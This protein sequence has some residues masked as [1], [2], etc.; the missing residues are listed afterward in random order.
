MGQASLQNARRSAGTLLQ[1]VCPIPTLLLLAMGMGGPDASLVQ[2]MQM[3]SQGESAPLA[4][5]LIGIPVAGVLIGHFVKRGF[6]TAYVLAALIGVGAFFVVFPFPV[7]GAALLYLLARV[8]V[9]EHFPTLEVSEI[10]LLRRL[11][12]SERLQLA[13]LAVVLIIAVA[14]LV[15][16]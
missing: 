1:I 3:F 13:L 14:V 10:E 8:C 11:L 4:G 16:A 5:L 9:Y 2:V 12:D 7:F 6:R 15:L